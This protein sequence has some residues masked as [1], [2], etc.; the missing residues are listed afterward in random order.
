[1]ELKLIDGDYV[2]NGR[3][4]QAA[5][6]GE[7]ALLQRVLFR[8][9]AR[10][11]AFPLLPEMGSRLWLLGRESGSGRLSA[12]RQYVAEA[13]TEEQVAVEDVALSDAGEGRIR[14]EARL[15]WEGGSLTAVVTI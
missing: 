1:M 4:G 3:G 15:L 2:D 12:A 10:R 7:E 8:L 13:L 5:L 6:E 14:L 9:T 11:G